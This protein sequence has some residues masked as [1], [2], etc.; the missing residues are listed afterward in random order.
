MQFICL[1]FFVKFCMLLKLWNAFIHVNCWIIL[2]IAKLRQSCNSY[3]MHKLQMIMLVCKINIFCL[4]NGHSLFTLLQSTT[5][6]CT[7]K[8]YPD[9]IQTFHNTNRTKYNTKIKTKQK[10]QNAKI[11]TWPNTKGENTNCQN[12]S[13]TKYKCNKI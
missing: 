11:Q 3:C 7:C 12:T 5:F 6:A 10:W 1:Y 9:K 4:H 8:G 2:T 13:V